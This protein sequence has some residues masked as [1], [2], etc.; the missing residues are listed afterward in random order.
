MPQEKRKPTHVLK[1]PRVG[2]S[3]ADWRKVKYDSRKAMTLYGRAEKVGV[4]ARDVGH[5]GGV[6][7]GEGNHVPQGRETTG[8]R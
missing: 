2:G 4:T 3:E 6:T 5:V 7:L 1:E 8:Y